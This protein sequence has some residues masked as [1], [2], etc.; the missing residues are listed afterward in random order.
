MPGTRAAGSEQGRDDR[1]QSG[2]KAASS[3]SK[4]ESMS[5]GGLYPW[6]RQKPD[7]VV[8]CDYAE[9]LKPLPPP[10]DGLCWVKRR[11]EATAAAVEVVEG[12]GPEEGDEE[13]GDASV[14]G[15]A[16]ARFVW[17]LV[18]KPARPST[19]EEEEEPPLVELEN[20][21]LPDFIE[22]TVLATDT[23]AGL[24]LRYKITPAELRKHN[25]FAGGA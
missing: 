6:R 21:D 7:G 13:G 22:H 20:D 14:V 24:R 10:P 11:I 8:Y 18:E 4:R 5:E 15:A 12:R 16:A 23:M 1:K 25:D 19:G 9:V 3:I 17:E 2:A